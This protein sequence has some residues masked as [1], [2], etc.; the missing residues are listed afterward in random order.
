MAHVSFTELIPA[1]VQSDSCFHW[2]LKTVGDQE[3]VFFFPFNNL[4][5]TH[6][7]LPVRLFSKTLSCSLSWRFTFFFSLGEPSSPSLF[8]FD[9]F[10]FH[11]LWFLLVMIFLD[12]S[13]THFLVLSVFAFTLY[14]AIFASRCLMKVFYLIY[15]VCWWK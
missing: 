9:V 3:C 8:C 1:G 5:C 13:G 6:Q 10:F 7:A 4:C 2:I 12:F 11:F 15:W 14:F